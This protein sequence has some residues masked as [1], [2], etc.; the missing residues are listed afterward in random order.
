MAAER[1]VIEI[2]LVPD[3]VINGLRNANCA[4]P[5]ERFETG[6]DVDAI[7]ENVVAVDDH[8]T[9]IDPDPQ[10]EAAIDRDWIIDRT[11]GQLHLDSAAQRVDNARKIREQ[12]VACCA[13][14]PPV[15]RCDQRIDGAA[16]SPSA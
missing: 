5:G 14:D 15:M 7:T 10:L 6:G 9:E 1:A 4:G 11:R 16:R 2:E 3:L 13:D 8:V 12:A